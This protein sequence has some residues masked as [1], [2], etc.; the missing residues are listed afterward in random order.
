MAHYA[1]YLG[2][3]AATLGLLLCGCEFEH[4]SLI[5]GDDAP[6]DAADTELHT[7]SFQQGVDSYASAQDTFLDESSADNLRGADTTFEYDLDAED[8]KM[9]VGLLR[10]DGIFDVIPAGA[11]IMSAIVTFDVSD[12]GDRP[13]ELHAALVEWSQTATTWNNFGGEPGV[14]SDELGPMIEPLPITS[15]MQSF[16]VTD[17]LNA[18]LR[19]DSNLGW[20]LVATST[21]GVE[22]R[23]SEDTQIASRPSLTVIWHR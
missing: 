10:F 2:L 23:S 19:G 7:S 22:M 12:S 9:T 6:A 14:Q 11:V 16:D 5:S 21:N 13:G 18:S 15:G 8:H 20:V 4:G 17:S 3:R 1:T